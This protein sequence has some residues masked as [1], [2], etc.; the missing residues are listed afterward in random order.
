MQETYMSLL[1]KLKRD[2]PEKKDIDFI[3][4]LMYKYSAREPLYDKI[5][6]HKK[7]FIEEDIEQL[8]EILESKDKKM[9]Q[10]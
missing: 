7:Y 2:G 3:N 6:D 5:S 1:L 4:Y 10:K 8:E 9:E